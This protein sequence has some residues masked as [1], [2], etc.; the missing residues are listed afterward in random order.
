MKGRALAGKLFRPIVGLLTQ[1]ISPDRIALSLAIGISVGIF[2]VLGSTSLLCGLAAVVF[3]LNL[4]A[5]QLVNWLVYPLQLILI[6]PFMQAGRFLF[7]SHTL[8]Y[9]A[10]QILSLVHNSPL[11]AISLLWVA[12]LQAI[13]VWILVCPLLALVLYL[14][15]LHAVPRLAIL[16]Q[17]RATPV[18]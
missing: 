18:G 10:T 6:L 16:A 9:T 15:L 11:Q 4:P 13:S 17:R 8:Q 2:P 7:G 1:G 5:I 3:R 14:P 12:T